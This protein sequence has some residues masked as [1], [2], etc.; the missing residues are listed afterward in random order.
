[1]VPC[2]DMANHASGDRTVAV[3]EVDGE[4]RAILLVREG[5]SVDEGGEVTIT[6]VYESHFSVFCFFLTFRLIYFSEFI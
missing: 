6:Y 4:G 5:V 1:M 3:Y 2:V